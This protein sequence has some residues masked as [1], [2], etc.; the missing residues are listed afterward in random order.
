MMHLKSG[1]Y[2]ADTNYKMWVPPPPPIPPS[3]SL[4][5]AEFPTIHVGSDTIYS[6]IVS[7]PAG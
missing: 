6:E 2:D 1:C 4:T 7:D 5:P 3:N